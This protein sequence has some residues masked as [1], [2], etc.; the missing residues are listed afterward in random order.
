M[1]GWPEDMF[2]APLFGKNWQIS[3]QAPWQ[4]PTI[5]A[6]ILSSVEDLQLQR[7]LTHVPMIYLVA[8]F[9]LI[10][11]MVLSAHEGV[12]TIYYAW[13]GLFA[14]G[15]FARMIMWM[16][17]PNHPGSH[18]RSQKM[19]RNLTV[20]SVGMVTF[21]SIWSVVAVAT[22]AFE[23]QM[24]IP[25]SLVFGST[26]IAHCLACIK[27]IAVTVLIVGVLPSALAMIIFGGFDEMIM[28]WSMI[29]IVLLMTRFIIDSY[30]QIISGLIMRH[31]I[32]KQAHSDTLTGLANR[33]AMM[34]H[35]YL[36]EQSFADKG[37][38]F[39]VAL[40]DLNHFKQVNDNLGH[41]IG[42][43]LLVEVA[44]RLNQSSAANEIVGRLGGD[45]FLILMPD[46]TG[47]D[48]AMARATAYLSG[49]AKP[50]NINGHILTP[51]ASVGI[52]VQTFDGNGAEQLLKAADKALY[53]M[54]RKGESARPIADQ[55]LRNIA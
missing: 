1:A 44:S 11:V 17:A 53:A 10:A 27:R 5:P 37:S 12:E 15:C 48:Q 3:W 45:E 21:L 4:S 29:T 26:C 35:L 41:D 16:R 22:D 47:R 25:M 18:A 34:N 30:N 51:S 42:D 50:A 7:A 39:A 32:W 36:A 13:M 2:L 43:H 24:F 19:L 31:T 55:P 14:I 9:N 20:I 52:A 46:V 6:E 23:N 38:G 8:I 49:F 28:G 54:K 33:R 40:I